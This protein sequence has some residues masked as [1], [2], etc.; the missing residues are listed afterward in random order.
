M[1]FKLNSRANQKPYSKWILI[2]CS[3]EIFTI[4]KNF[5]VLIKAIQVSNN[6]NF[7]SNFTK[8]YL[9]FYFQGIEKAVDIWQLDVN[10][11]RYVK[12]YTCLDKN[13]KEKQTIYSRGSQNSSKLLLEIF[14]FSPGFCKISYCVSRFCLCSFYSY[15]SRF[16]GH[17]L[18]LCTNHRNK[19]PPRAH[20]S[21][22]KIS[23][24]K[25]HFEN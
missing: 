9:T 14:Q 21:R 8:S 12:E 18:Q 24:Q 7:W 4:S 13:L 5:G 17:F 3:G 20:W 1:T 22:F 2:R 19:W 25:C 6:E 15:V 11:F 10:T 23:I 16:F